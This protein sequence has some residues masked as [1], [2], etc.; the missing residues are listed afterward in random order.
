MTTQRSGEV[1]GAAAGRPPDSASCRSPARPRSGA[2]C[3]DRPRTT[4]CGSPWS[5]AATRRSSC[6]PTPT[7]T[8]RS[9]A[10]W[11]PRCATSGRPAPPPTGSTS[12]SRVAEEFAARLAERMGAMTVGRGPDD[13]V[14]VGPLIDAKRGRPR[15]A[16]WSTTRSSGRPVL[17]GGEPLGRAGLLLP[18]DGPR[19]R[20]RRRADAAARRSSAR[21]RRSCRSRPTTRCIAEANDT[22]YGLVAYVFTRDLGRARC[23]WPRASRPGWSASTRAWCRTRRLRSAAS[24]SPA[25]A[26][27][28]RTRA[29]TEYLDD[30]VRRHR[31]LTTTR[32]RFWGRI[33]A[34]G[35]HFHPESPLVVVA[36]GHGG[37]GGMGRALARGT[38]R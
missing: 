3:I 16:S 31:R 29:S 4:C 19:R 34:P 17:L 20:A 35:R 8:P 12:T 1:V 37:P 21:S 14:Q 6:S 13:G 27:R 28:G 25:S 11:W 2:C 5:W 9:T 18:A 26:T 22:E 30:Q 38:V 24:S 32:T 36:G 15:S 23:G 7:W 10:P 33:C